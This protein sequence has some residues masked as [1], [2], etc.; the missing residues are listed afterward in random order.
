MLCFATVEPI[1]PHFHGD[2]DPLKSSYLLD[3]IHSVDEIESGEAR[4]RA[5]ALKALW[6]A[7]ANGFA[8]TQPLAAFCKR[9]AQRDPL[10]LVRWSEQ[11]DGTAACQ[12]L[13]HVLVRCQ[14]R[15]RARMAARR[16]RTC[17]PRAV[18][19]R[20]RSGRPLA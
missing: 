7:R 6:I 1:N 16:A 14:R 2:H 20:Q 13:T 9:S 3:I 18:V 10:Q 11:A 12:L 19:A 8:P 17:H 15:W 5:D 4:E